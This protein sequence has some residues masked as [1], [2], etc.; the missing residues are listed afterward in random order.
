M[1]LSMCC[2]P[3]RLPGKQASTRGTM[4]ISAVFHSSQFVKPPM[5]AS[6]WGASPGLSLCLCSCATLLALSARSSSAAPERPS[7]FGLF[8]V[9]FSICPSRFVL[10]L[11]FGRLSWSLSL[12]LSLSLSSLHP[13]SHHRITAPLFFAVF[14]VFFFSL[15]FIRLLVFLSAA[16]EFI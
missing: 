13:P 11:C 8:S 14:V 2:L 12:S 16:S 7:S 6:T 9:S 5:T 4:T 15:L 1:G 3:T 10:L